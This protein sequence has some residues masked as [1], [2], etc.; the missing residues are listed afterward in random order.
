[1]G[2][3]SGIMVAKEEAKF[4]DCEAYAGW[5]SHSVELCVEKYLSLRKSAETDMDGTIRLTFKAGDY[6]RWKA[7]P[8]GLALEPFKAGVARIETE[9]TMDRASIRRAS[10]ALQDGEMLMV[11]SVE[12]GSP[13]ALGKVEVDWL[14]SSVCGKIPRGVASVAQFVEEA[15]GR[16][17]DVEVHFTAGPFN[18][19]GA[20]P[21]GVTRPLWIHVFND[22]I[23]TGDDGAPLQL[24]LTCMKALQQAFPEEPAGTAAARP[25]LIMLALL[26]RE[27]LTARLQMIFQCLDVK[28]KMT[29]AETEVDGVINLF[30]RTLRHMRYLRNAVSE[31]AL[32]ALTESLASHCTAGLDGTRLRVDLC[33]NQNIQFNVSKSES[34]FVEFLSKFRGF[35]ERG[36]VV[37]KSAK[38]TSI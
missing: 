14:V 7:P 30:T 17:D 4:P 18:H 28:N 15:V 19:G 6:E 23:E 21:T 3:A 2:A 1:M 5:P 25:A 9:G 37:Q 31:D 20:P 11:R 16:G 36:T 32:G 26:C 33:G 27:N 38:T 12:A 13:A 35:D 24:P 34:I 8:F 29:V 10:S 22:P